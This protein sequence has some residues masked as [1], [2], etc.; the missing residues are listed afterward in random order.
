MNRIKI[1][2]AIVLSCTGIMAQNQAN[3]TT[4]FVTVDFTTDIVSQYLWRGMLS[5]SSPNIQPYIGVNVGNFTLSA[6]SSASFTGNFAEI[7]ITASYTLGNLTLSVADYF[8]TDIADTIQKPGYF[9]WDNKTTPHSLEAL[10][11][12]QGPDKF[13]VMVTAGV[14]IYGDDLNEQR[15]TNNYSTYFELGYPFTLSNVSFDIFAGATFNSGLYADS[16]AFV[17]AGLN[18][19]KDIKITDSFTLPVTATFAINPYA[20][21]AFF[22]VAVSF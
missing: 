13:P 8:D 22:I 19:S 15:D 3:D 10:A 9:V 6:W 14:F 20:D 12:W 7:D 2:F 16:F 1:F 17:N 18:A 11:F 5:N 4:G 21:Q